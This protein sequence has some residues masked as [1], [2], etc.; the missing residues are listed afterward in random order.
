VADER[1]VAELFDVTE[2]HFGGVDAVVHAAGRQVL[3]PLVELELRLLD[4]LMRTN[5]RG[6][7][8]VDQQAA[9]R[10]RRGGSIINFSSSALGRPLLKYTAYA[11]TKGAIEAI[12]LMLANELRGRDINVNAVAPGPTETEMFVEGRDD[13]TLARVRQSSPLE[14]MGT[15]DDIAEVVAFLTSP[16]G[17]WVNGQRIRAN[18]GIL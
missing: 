3:A 7:F 1:A 14:R 4:E 16:A 18:G 13:A 6:T 12:S 10:V 2:E 9:Q 17:H 11:A 8:V 15:P 5:I